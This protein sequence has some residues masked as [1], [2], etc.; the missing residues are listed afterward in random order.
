MKALNASNVPRREFDH[1]EHA[2]VVDIFTAQRAGARLLDYRDIEFGP[3]V[4]ALR[5][6][7]EAP[8]AQL[9]VAGRVS[10]RV[11]D[12]QVQPAGEVAIDTQVG[13]V[14]V[15]AVEADEVVLPVH[16]VTMR[17]ERRRQ[18]DSLI[19]GPADSIDGIG[20]AGG[21]AARRDQEG[22]LA[23]VDLLGVV[24]IALQDSLRSRI[25][26]ARWEARRTGSSRQAA[27]AGGNGSLPSGPIQPCCGG[28]NH[29]TARRRW[30]L[31]R[32]A[33]GR[34]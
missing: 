5:R 24:V 14:V 27:A 6:V 13:R 30:E 21:Y 1:L 15:V 28:R 12:A 29:H 32:P 8:V 17:H 10:I 7:D 18:G 34:P 25:P 19:L 26:P 33:Q 22:A 2:E 3:H 9:L 4:R 16:A 23:V 20:R 11:G 31:H